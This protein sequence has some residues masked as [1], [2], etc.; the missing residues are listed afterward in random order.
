[1][2]ERY[3]WKYAISGENA[4]IEPQPPIDIT[5]YAS[6]PTKYVAIIDK[7]SNILIGVMLCNLAKG[8]FRDEPENAFLV[9]ISTLYMYSPTYGAIVGK[10]E[11]YAVNL[12]DNFCR[13][14]GARE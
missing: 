8:H 11:S 6:E 9:P 5:Q 3:F 2:N 4:E 7:K 14:I 12:K 10:Q 1:M 13:I